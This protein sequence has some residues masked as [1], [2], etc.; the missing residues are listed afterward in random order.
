MR[1]LTTCVLREGDHDMLIFSRV[2]ECEDTTAT[3]I[4]DPV[5]TLPIIATINP[6][7][8]H[9]SITASAPPMS[10]RRPLG[11]NLPLGWGVTI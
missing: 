5:P 3:L 9:M 11:S 10:K 1:A 8:T 6:T 4:S 7:R 2:A